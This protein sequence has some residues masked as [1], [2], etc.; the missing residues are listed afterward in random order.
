MHLAFD[1]NSFENFEQRLTEAYA[2]VR[3]R[4]AG[5]AN[6]IITELGLCYGDLYSLIAT[7]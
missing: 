7:I 1:S 2:S 3:V 6:E 5:E 4:N